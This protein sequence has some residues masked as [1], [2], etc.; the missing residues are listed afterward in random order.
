VR[1]VLRAEKI[2]LDRE[3]SSDIAGEVVDVD[4]LG[5]LARY[6]IEIAGGQHLTALA[7]IRNGVR[8]VG[9]RVAVRIAPE[10]CRIL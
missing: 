9:D 2:D 6:E 7:A 5:A 1:I 8:A 10:H 4:Y 3:G